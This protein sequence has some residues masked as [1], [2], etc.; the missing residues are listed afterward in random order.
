MTS[1]SRFRG[2]TVPDQITITDAAGD[3]VNV[4]G[5]S[6]LL[7]VNKNKDPSS[8]E[9]QLFQVAGV[10]ISGPAGTVKFTPTANQTDQLPGKYYYDIQMTDGGGLIKTIV[11]GSYVIKQDVTK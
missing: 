8:T 4:T 2:D 1:I 5:Y 10:I 7:T 6:F 3:P 9:G 11:T